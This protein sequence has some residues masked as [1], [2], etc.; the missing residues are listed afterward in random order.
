MCGDMNIA[1]TDDDVFDPD[2][3][4]GQTHVT[5][6][7]RAALAEL[8]A[9]GLHDVVR[10]RWPSER[11]FSYWDYRAGMFHQ[12]L[13][14]RIDLVLASEPVAGRVRAAWIDRQARKGKGPSD[15]APVIVD[16]DEAPDG[17]IGPVVP[18]PSAPVVEARLG[19]AAAVALAARPRLLA[20][21]HTRAMD[22]GI[23]GRVALVG[24]ATQGIGR[25]CAE[26]L[27][28]EGA[29]VVVTAREDDRT[30]A[31]AAEIGAE[32]GFGWDTGDVDG[33]AALVDR[34]EER[35]GQVDIVVTN[36]GGPPAGADPLGFTES[37]WETA[38]RS[39]V[40]GPLALL[41]RVLP[42]MRER[43]WGRVVGIASTSVREPLPILMLS[44]AE[45]SATL[46]AYKTL[47]RD[48]AGDGVTINTLLTGQIATARIA[49]LYGSMETAE[50]AAA[51]TIPVGRMG[52]PE[53]MAWA[54]A[55][56]CS[57]RAA[58]ITGS[59]LAVD[60]GVLRAI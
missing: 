29:R 7:E 52:R 6:P 5:P 26:V 32:A 58:Y 8:Q 37:Q 41:R 57:D 15:H 2:A 59:A 23:A 34:V 11:V 40:L 30:A 51:E 44:N 28:A 16:L 47:A 38:H 14:M 46:A 36:T 25:A 12:D 48:V 20:A 50:A 39:L 19:Q 31:V 43:R 21:R 49:E 53:E 24:G 4:I 27:V 10:D 1:P 3:Y 17:D 9:L 45:R 55:F 54:A 13:G 56:L 35:V 18:P 42:G 33:A 22:L 60:G